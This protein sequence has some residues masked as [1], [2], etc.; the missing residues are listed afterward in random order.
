M[1]LCLK[2]TIVNVFV[3]DVL[4]DII[5]FI[6]GKLMYLCI[7]FIMCVDTNKYNFSMNG[8]LFNDIY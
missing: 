3:Y 8:V 5:N 2:C 4:V 7:H 1:L 6:F